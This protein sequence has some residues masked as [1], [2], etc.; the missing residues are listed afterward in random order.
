VFVAQ[1]WG[2]GKSYRKIAASKDIRS[3]V[4]GMQHAGHE[5]ALYAHIHGSGAASDN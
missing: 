5:F 3:E 4:C 1:I 2:R